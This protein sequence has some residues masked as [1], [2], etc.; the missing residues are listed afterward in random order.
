MTH[1]IKN[2]IKQVYSWNFAKALSAS[3][4]STVPV[5][6]GNDYDEPH[7]YKHEIQECMCHPIAFHVKMLGII[8][9]LHQALKQD[10]SA[11][12]IEAI[13]REVSSHVY[14]KHWELIP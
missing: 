7:N 9:Y 1:D 8:I 13:V 4:N 5:F 11:K 10:D 2:S 3:M 12:F 14:E 6:L